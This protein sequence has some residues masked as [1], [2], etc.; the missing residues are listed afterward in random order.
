MF[1]ISSNMT[2]QTAVT[3]T[4]FFVSKPVNP[5]CV[6]MRF[7]FLKLK[8][9]SAKMSLRV[10]N[11][12][13]RPENSCLFRNWS[14]SGVTKTAKPTTDIVCL[15]ADKVSIRSNRCYVMKLGCGFACLRKNRLVGVGLS[16]CLRAAP[17][18]PRLLI[19]YPARYGL[20]ALHFTQF[21]ELTVAVEF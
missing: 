13:Y 1:H 12:N 11:V 21:L 3:S 7:L 14:E 19:N 10:R 6:R 16:L 17:P 20:L 9:K 18:P 15:S 8:E 5:F 4:N 2:T